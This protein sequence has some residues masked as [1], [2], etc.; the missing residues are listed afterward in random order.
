MIPFW[1]VPPGMLP[2]CTSCYMILNPIVIQVLAINGTAE[3]REFAK[4]C[5]VNMAC[6]GKFSSDRT[7]MDYDREIWHT[8]SE[9]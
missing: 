2:M 7:I 4:K 1:R 5:F 9:K 8:S 3:K 6:A